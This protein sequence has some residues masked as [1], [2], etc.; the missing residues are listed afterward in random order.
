M[1]GQAG[2]GA[3]SG[4][5]RQALGIFVLALSVRLLHVFQLRDAPFFAIKLGDA[6]FFDT[7]AHELAG[8]DWL[9]HEVFWYAPLYP[10]FL[11]IVYRVIGADPLAA[12]LIQASIGAGS[13]VLLA[14][15]GRRWCSPPAGLVA[16]LILAL[17]GPAVFYD[18]LFQKPVL[19]SFF[20]CLLLWV[21]SRL[22][23]RPGRPRIWFCAGLAAGALTLTRENALI[24]VV[25]LLFWLLAFVPERTAQKVA[26]AAFLVLGAALVL[27]PVAARN[28]LVGG[29]FHLTA[30]NFGDNFYKGNNPQATGT[31][32]PLRAGRGSPRFERQDATELAEVALGRELT[33]SEVS[34]Y[35]TEKSLDYIRSHPVDWLRLMGRKGV[36]F[37][38][39][40]E[41]SDAEDPYT[42]AEWSVP[43][44]A[45]LRVTHFGSLAPLAL[46]GVWVLWE[47]RRRLWLLYLMLAS[48]SASVIAF[49]VFGR[50]RYPIVP[51][52]VLLAAGGLTG[53]SRFHREN[54][55]RR[56]AYC[57]ATVFVV[58]VLCNWPVFSKSGI[59]SG[60]EVGIGNELQISGHSERALE[61]F[62]RAAE[63]D[64]KNASSQFNLGVTFGSQ[65]NSADARRAYEAALRIRPDYFQAHTNLGV[66]LAERGE[67]AEA[68]RHFREALRSDSHGVSALVN[69]SRL[70][71]MRGQLDEAT[72]QAEEAARRTR[73]SDLA[74]LER[75]EACYAAAGDFDRAARIVDS[76]LR[77]AG[78]GTN[79]QAPEALRQRLR[80]YRR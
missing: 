8:G 77:L 57:W 50:Y 78:S 42:H 62:R 26:C 54:S 20:V 61:H 7:W 9:G 73:Y 38:N 3:N 1:R 43:L 36:L 14:S 71:Q 27:L 63:L 35:W 60:T 67:Y 49:Y 79:L 18:G 33:P 47:Q 5:R 37:C 65:G 39:S 25:V 29:E 4:F 19:D 70:L 10:Y 80:N 48:Y 55:W 30:A 56:I 58:G 74:V 40:L 15:A 6:G 44:G 52:L 17:F 64:P 16:G 45:L 68:E 2:S 72:R 66:V 69:L 23:D 11:G 41:W 28:R 34:S 32:M 24:F 59:R 31:Y 46:F 21:V 12:R 53:A 76:A 13:C 22:V 75:L 51:L